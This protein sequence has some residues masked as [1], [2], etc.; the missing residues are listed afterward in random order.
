VA[1]NSVSEVVVRQ[2]TPSLLDDWLAF[3]DR[4]AFVDN[5]D[6]AGCYC[7]WFH[8]D[9]TE[10]DWDSRTP[11]ENREAS[12]GLIGTGRLRGYLAYVDGR[13]AGW[14]QAAPR[15][16]IPYITNEAEFAVD[17]AAEVGSIVCFVVATEFRQQGV[18]ARLLEAACAGFKEEGLRTAEAYPSRSA[19]TAAANY[20]GPLSLYLRAGFKPFKE[21]QS[22]V[23][24]R[25]DLAGP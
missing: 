1:S 18:A 17:D 25:R 23:M 8:A 2:L 10:K 3:F 4:D 15:S 6:W 16:A 7:Y 24:V 20:H 21:L 11:E 9:H 22:L 12:I 14:C 13:P 5:P 19:K